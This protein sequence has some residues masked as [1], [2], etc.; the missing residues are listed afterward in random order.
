MSFWDKPITIRHLRNTII[1]VAIVLFV[2][3][4]FIMQEQIYVLFSND[5]NLLRVLKSLFSAG[6][7]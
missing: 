4:V 6:K 3:K 7:V 1:I 5:A 2:A